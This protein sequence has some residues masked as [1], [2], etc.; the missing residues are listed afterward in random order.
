MLLNPLIIPHTHQAALLRMLRT[1]MDIGRD[2]LHT[3]K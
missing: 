3:D 1:L 2:L